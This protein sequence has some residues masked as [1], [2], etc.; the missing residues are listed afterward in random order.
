M[1]Y[2]KSASHFWLQQGRP[3]LAREALTR[4]LRHFRAYARQAPPATLELIPGLEYLLVLD[5]VY[6]EQAQTPLAR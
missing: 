3:E 5:Q 2:C 6:L 4:V 1:F